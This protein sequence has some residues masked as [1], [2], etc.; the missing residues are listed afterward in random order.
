MD[1]STT[2]KRVIEEKKHIEDISIKKVYS[3]TIKNWLQEAWM[4]H[5]ELSI[6]FRNMK[7]LLEFE[8][9]SSKNHITNDIIRN[10][11]EI[12][13]HL[14][15]L[16]KYYRSLDMEIVSYPPMKSTILNYIN[17]NDEL[18]KRV[19]HLMSNVNFSYN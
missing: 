16:K 5:K 11:Y 2:E 8:E 10:L 9:K 13:I 6:E 14:R 17:Y 7:I 1:I 12:N 19:E 3:K 18:M 15:I 4:H